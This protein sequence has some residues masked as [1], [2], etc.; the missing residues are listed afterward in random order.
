MTTPPKRERRKNPNSL[1]Q[2]A[3]AAEIDPHVVYERVRWGWPDSLALSVPVQPPGGM[4]R[5]AK[6]EAGLRWH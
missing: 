1:R 2:R 6:I 5:Q 4:T 3:I